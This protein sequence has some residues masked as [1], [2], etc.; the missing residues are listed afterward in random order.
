M[1][2]L[3]QGACRV[4]DG[5]SK[6]AETSELERRGCGSAAKAT[7]A[8]ISMSDRSGVAFSRC[9][10]CCRWLLRCSAVAN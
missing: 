2:T 1:R 4:G 5:A 3:L 8:C 9:C 6:E 10:V 7:C